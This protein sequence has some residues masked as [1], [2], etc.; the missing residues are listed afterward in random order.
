MDSVSLRRSHF[1]LGDYRNDYGTTATDQNKMIDG[2]K[3]Y[4]AAKLDPSLKN[5]L[6]RSH[7]TLGNFKTD[8]QTINQ[9]EY[10]DKSKD[11]PRQNSF[12]DHI[13]TLRSHNHKL[14]NAM[15]E[16]L[17]ETQHKFSKPVLDANI[18]GKQNISTKELQRSHYQ[19][20]NDN[21]NYSTTMQS[22]YIPKIQGVKFFSKDLT[23]TNMILGTDN[24]DMKSSFTTAFVRHDIKP[25]SHANKDLANDL[26]RH[27]FQ[28]GN[29]N[30][31]KI[32]IN[33][34]DYQ[35]HSNKDA[36]SFGRTISNQMLRKSHIQLGNP[37]SKLEN[38]TYSET[39]VPHL[40]HKKQEKCNNNNYISSIF[41]ANDQDKGSFATETRSNYNYKH[42]K[43]ISK[44]DKA[45]LKNVIKE[46]KRHHY[47]FGR[48]K[49]D[50][51]TTHSI[52]YKYNLEKALKSRGNLEQ[53]L[54]QDLR[55][56]HYKIGYLDSSNNTTTH[57]STY[58]P[59]IYDPANKAQV[60]SELR[61]SHFGLSLS[62][63]M[64][65]DKTTYMTDYTKKELPQEN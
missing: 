23:R 49:D 55:S 34:Q 18:L 22:S 32:S 5:D 33:Q 42:P 48:D 41:L 15:P 60:S 13:K 35:D 40:N 17:S 44:D 61:K 50:Y 7:F 45:N 64:K 59:L 63:A 2:T 65:V 53:G 39:M 26:R 46:I 37:A 21:V 9:R 57:L 54:I 12:G 4:D 6:R 3:R 43:G 31:N 8:L 14:G 27:H 24:P 36:L 16:Y 10:I 58:K 52:D 20:G 25:I 29:E 62:D 47:N 19:F 1:R 38:T 51:N 56:T 11:R 28:L 30:P